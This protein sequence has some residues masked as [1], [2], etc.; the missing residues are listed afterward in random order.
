MTITKFTFHIT[1]LQIIVGPVRPTGHNFLR[2]SKNCFFWQTQWSANI[3]ITLVL[4]KHIYNV[5]KNH[6]ALVKY[7]SLAKVARSFKKAF[8]AGPKCLAEHNNYLHLCCQILSFTFAVLNSWLDKTNLAYN[9]SHSV[10][11]FLQN[12]SH[13]RPSLLSSQSSDSKILVNCSP[14][15]RGHSSYKETFSLQKG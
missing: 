10:V 3:L 8:L 11:I 15:L 12:P 6:Q 9:I 13:Q 2:S 4:Y 14:P 7:V 5:F 1:D